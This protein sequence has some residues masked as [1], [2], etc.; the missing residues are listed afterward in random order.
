MPLLALAKERFDPDLALVYRFLVSEGLL[1][2]FHAL[3]ILRKQGTM[4]LPPS[5]ALRTLC[6]HW[7][8]VT[9]RWVCT[10]SDLLPALLSA[11]GT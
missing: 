6:F 5:V 3:Q 2:P 8:G 10:V 11:K 4:Q 7:T 1:I 9:R